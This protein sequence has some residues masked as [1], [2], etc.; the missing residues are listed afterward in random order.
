MPLPPENLANDE[1]EKEEVPAEMA[2]AAEDESLPDS[3]A[4]DRKETKGDEES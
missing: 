4:D 1:G 2:E 3:A